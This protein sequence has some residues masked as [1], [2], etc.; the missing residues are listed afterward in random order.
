M[1]LDSDFI[2]AVPDLRTLPTNLSRHVGILP[3][4]A[5]TLELPQNA[6]FLF[7]P[8]CFCIDDFS[9]LFFHQKLPH[10]PAGS[11]NKHGKVLVVLA[12][13]PVMISH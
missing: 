7:L 4:S 2:V 3:M 5:I 11:V 8:D 9:G 1:N 6:S 12:S 13:V 10:F